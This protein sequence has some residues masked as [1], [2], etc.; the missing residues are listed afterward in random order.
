MKK[1]KKIK[2]KFIPD[3]VENRTDIK[4]AVFVVSFAVYGQVF[5]KLLSKPKT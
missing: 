4:F 1:S 5:K 2:E 3:L